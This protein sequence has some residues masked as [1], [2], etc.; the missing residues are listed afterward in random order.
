MIADEPLV[1]VSVVVPAVVPC[2]GLPTLLRALYTDRARAVGI[3]QIVVVD[4]TAKGSPFIAQAVE[5]LVTTP[6]PGPALTYIREAIAG[7]YRAR[8]TGIRASSGAVLAFLDV[9]VVP[10]DSWFDAVRDAA[11]DRAILRATGPVTQVISVPA[12]R[13]LNR[14]AQLL[15]LVSGINQR[16]YSADGWAATANLLVRR[17]IIEVVG[18][19]NGRLES[20]GDREFGYRCQNAGYPLTFDERMEVCHEARATLRALVSKA[21]RVSRGQV[22]L[23]HLLGTDGYRNLLGRELPYWWPLGKQLRLGIGLLVGRWAPE[24][25]LR[26][27]GMAALVT[28]VVG[29][30][31]L[32]ERRRAL[33]RPVTSGLGPVQRRNP[34]SAE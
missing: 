22:Q 4:N 12:G 1:G 5:D 21:Q 23:R 24:L 29:L 31:G 9:D 20:S 7:S 34:R 3:E 17:S 8:N 30:A 11:A 10:T 6:R 19:F 26:K 25:C 15:D 33:R 18:P 28:P 2:P 13:F 16:A 14:C 27:R 32:V